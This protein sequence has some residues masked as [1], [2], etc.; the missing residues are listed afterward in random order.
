MENKKSIETLKSLSESELRVE[1]K[2]CSVREKHE[3]ALLIEHLVEIN[4]RLLHLKWGFDSLYSYLTKELG[5][6]SGAASLRVSAVRATETISNLPQKIESGELC[7]KTVRAVES[8]DYHER[9]ARGKDLTKT[10]KKEIYEMVG[11]LSCS[12]AEA[13]LADLSTSPKYKAPDKE[14]D[15]PVKGSKRLIQFSVDDEE[16]EV[17]QL[18]RE[19]FSHKHPGATTGELYKLAM[20]DVGYRRHPKFK[21]ERARKPKDEVLK[22][23]ATKEET[24]TQF[25]KLENLEAETPTQFPKLENLEVGSQRIESQGTESQ[26]TESQGT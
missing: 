8:F 15:R 10:E 1:T 3:T 6:E 4:H 22:N 16:Y 18:V 25:P 14:V 11:N 9:K 7:L 19:V 20:K 2:N 13:R 24:P 17:L 5:Y 23:E 12:K 21:A 26:G